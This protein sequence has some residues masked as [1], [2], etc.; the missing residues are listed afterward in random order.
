MGRVLSW[1]P[2]LVPLSQWQALPS[3]ALWA[4]TLLPECAEDSSGRAAQVQIP[5]PRPGVL[6]QDIWS[7]AQSLPF[8]E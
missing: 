1:Y 4:K 6:T 3:P 2:D 7:R 8:H 5:G